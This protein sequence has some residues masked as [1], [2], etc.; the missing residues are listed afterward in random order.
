MEKYE[1][2]NELKDDNRFMVCSD[3][4]RRHLDPFIQTKNG[5]KRISEISK[6][7]KD[8]IDEYLKSTKDKYIYINFQ[9]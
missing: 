2:S 7:V 6:E 3:V 5:A 9:F 8:Q 4:K 1:T